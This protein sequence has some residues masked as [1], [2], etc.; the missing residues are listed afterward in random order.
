MLW[1]GEERCLKTCGWR[2]YDPSIPGQDD[3]DWLL[4]RLAAFDNYEQRRSDAN[5]SHDLGRLQ[6]GTGRDAVTR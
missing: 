4:F 2:R 5:K 1:G 3:G 6:I